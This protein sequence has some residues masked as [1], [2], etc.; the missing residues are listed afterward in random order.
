MALVW[1]LSGEMEDGSFL[2][3]KIMLMFVIAQSTPRDPLVRCTSFD[4]DNNISA[5]CWVLLAWG[6]LHDTLW[7]SPGPLHS[8]WSCESLGIWPG[9]KSMLIVCVRVCACWEKY[10]QIFLFGS[11]YNFQEVYIMDV[12]KPP[13]IWGFYDACVCVCV[14][15]CV[16]QRVSTV[17][18]ETRKLLNVCERW[19]QTFSLSCLTCTHSQ[20]LCDSY[21]FSLQCVCFC[22][23]TKCWTGWNHSHIFNSIHKHSTNGHLW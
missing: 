18:L 9:P 13:W 21:P 3:I 4:N 16:C 23:N 8:H 19:R 12:L 22:V 6:W 1:G 2:S 14:C 20:R 5:A 10:W 17:V 7:R 11:K 15:V